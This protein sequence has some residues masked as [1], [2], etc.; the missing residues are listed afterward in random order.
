M[1]HLIPDNK[2][3]HCLHELFYFKYVI[4]KCIVMIAFMSFSSNI[5]LKG[6]S[7]HMPREVWDGIT[8]PF[9]NFN[10]CNIEG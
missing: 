6:I 8:Y 7:N 2:F 5:A 1:Q 10:G 9:L 4:F 3:T